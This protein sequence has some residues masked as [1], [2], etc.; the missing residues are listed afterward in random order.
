MVDYKQTAKRFTAMLLCV[1][2]IL[3]VA[4][5][6]VFAENTSGVKKRGSCG[7]NVSYV[8]YNDGEMVISGEGPCSRFINDFWDIQYQLKKVTVEEGVT[9]IPEFTY[10]SLLTEVSLPSTMTEIAS[11]AFG[12]TSLQKINIPDS[13]KKIGRAAFIYC[14]KLTEITLPDGLETIEN[15]AFYGCNSLKSINIPKSVATIGERT[16]HI[17]YSMTEIDVDENN[18]NFASDE[19]GALYNKDKTVLL[20]Y[21]GGSEASEYVMPDT[22]TRVLPSSFESSKFEHIVFSDKITTIENR[23]F[24]GCQNLREINIPDGVT[25]IEDFAFSKCNALTDIYIPKNVETIG[26]SVFQSSSKLA[27]I[28][29]DKDNPNYSSDENGVLFN[30]DKTTLIYYPQGKQ[31]SVYAVPGSVKTLGESSFY[32]CSSLENLIIPEGVERFELYC[33]FNAGNIKKIAL[34]ESTEFIDTAAFRNCNSL[35]SLTIP[36]GAEISYSVF[37]ETSVPN[38]KTIYIVGTEEE[39]NRKTLPSGNDILTN[40]E[41]TFH[42]PEEHEFVYESTYEPTCL[43]DGNDIYSCSICGQTKYQQLPAK[44]HTWDD[45][46]ITKNPTCVEKGEK[47]FRC[48]VCGTER[49][50]ELNKDGD[51]HSG[52][53]VV[54]NVKASTCTENGYTGDTVCLDCGTVL[55]KGDSLDKLSHN[56]T[57]KETAAPTCAAEGV[58]TYTCSDCGDSYIMAIP[59]TGAH[60]WII[61]P[62][63]EPTCEEY[64]YTEGKICAVCGYLASE[65]KEIA[66]TG[67]HPGEWTVIKEATCVS[68]GEKTAVCADC[69]KELTESIAVDPEH[70]IDA[71]HNGICDN[72]LTKVEVDCDC[73]CHNHSKLSKIIWKIMRVIWKLFGGDNLRYC[74]CGRAHW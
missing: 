25:V 41:L 35:E 73:Y 32:D 7:D 6:T 37:Y 64:G 22:V 33:F 57:A 47:I 39:W 71:N 40:H 1:L 20:Q 14:D 49:V 9:T 59:A 23:T 45:G 12:W 43:H 19:Y 36:V 3:T 27:S 2:L 58:M 67:H 52:E 61:V 21:P 44:E 50:E 18:P 24:M 4:P 8:F 54:I 26:K 15:Q 11:S 38:V 62:A 29:V 42:A 16:F 69:G 51:R 13:V 48:V 53:T 31:E 17:C 30:K 34:P 66:P 56:Y 55:K 72:C 60:V 46:E 74:E 63:V 10:S 28:T 65:R 5:M 68:A 70:H